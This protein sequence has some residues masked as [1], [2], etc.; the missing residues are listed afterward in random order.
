MI[1]ATRDS[2]TSARCF[3]SSGVS[4]VVRGGL[5]PHGSA[6]LPLPT[7]LPFAGAGLSPLLHAAINAS[8]AMYFTNLVAIMGPLDRQLEHEVGPGRAGL[9]RDRPVMVVEDLLDDR[10]PEPRAALPTGRE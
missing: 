3:R 2:A 10:E 6:A 4:G 9:D 1:V 8:T 5:P 7:A